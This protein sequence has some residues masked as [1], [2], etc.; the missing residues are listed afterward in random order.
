MAPYNLPLSRNTTLLSVP[1]EFWAGSARPF[2]PLRPSSDSMA[3]I[4]GDDGH[5]VGVDVLAQVDALIKAGKA[6]IDEAP[7]TYGGP[8]KKDYWLTVETDEGWL[9]ISLPLK[10]AF[11]KGDPIY[12]FTTGLTI[13]PRWRGVILE[14]R[15]RDRAL[16]QWTDRE[17]PHPCEDV[18]VRSLRFLPAPPQS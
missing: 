15:P 1:V 9:K 13:A 3:E 7:P 2:P 4:M 12:G 17:D 18:P 6:R 5:F 10:P 11:E 16:V 14:L 8:R